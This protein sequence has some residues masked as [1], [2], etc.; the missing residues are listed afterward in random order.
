[1][2]YFKS[3]D[4]L[5]IKIVLWFLHKPFQNIDIL[6][7]KNF[8]GFFMNLR[9]QNEWENTNIQKYFVVRTK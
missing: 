8:F 5:Y 6:C 3:N 4:N 9:I 2:R 1:M 7:I